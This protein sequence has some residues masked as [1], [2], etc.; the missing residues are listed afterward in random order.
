MGF[1][2]LMMLKWGFLFVVCNRTKKGKWGIG[3]SVTTF[4]RWDLCLVLLLFWINLVKYFQEFRIFWC[5]HIYRQLLIW[6]ICNLCRKWER[7]FTSRIHWTSRRWDLFLILLLFWT[8][9]SFEFMGFVYFIELICFEKKK[10]MWM[11]Y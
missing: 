8:K 7:N 4:Q 10:K 5:L 11:I 1:V 3:F 9:F 6:L 2:Y